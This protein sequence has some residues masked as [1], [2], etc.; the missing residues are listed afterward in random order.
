[1]LLQHQTFTLLQSFPDPG[2]EEEMTFGV[3]EKPRGG[4]KKK[5]TKRSERGVRAKGGGE[6]AD[7]HEHQTEIDEERWNGVA[8]RNWEGV[9]EGV[10]VELG[11]NVHEDEGDD[12][13][14]A[15]EVKDDGDGDEDEHDEH[16]YT[17]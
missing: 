15:E 12:E 17:T 6:D 7:E 8:G 2:W 16:E 14:E 11:R 4:T 5:G 10:Q 1:M 3:G 13:G 9:T